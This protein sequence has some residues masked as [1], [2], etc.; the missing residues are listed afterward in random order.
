MK[1]LNKLPLETD[2]RRFAAKVPSFPVSAGELVELALKGRSRSE[3]ADFYQAFAADIVF[4]D[5]DDLLAR[6]EQVG[7]LN[8]EDHPREE[9]HA[10]EED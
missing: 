3:I 2:L 4:S 6:S 8:S 7:V 9:Y 5:L 1:V 10:P